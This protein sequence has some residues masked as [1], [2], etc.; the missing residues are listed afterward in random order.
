MSP[1][2][3]ARGWRRLWEGTLRL[4]EEAV[5][6]LA[7]FVMLVVILYQVFMR[8]VLSRPPIWADELARYLYI[9][10]VFLGAALVSRRGTHI[11]MEY[12]P[13]RLRGRSRSLVLLVHEA[14]IVAILLYI[15]KSG[16]EFYRFYARIP[17]PAM[18]LPSAFVVV[19][20][21]LSCVL[22]LLHH[23]ARAATHIQSL[24][25]R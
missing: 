3:A 10:M 23:L 14:A 24:R 16:L 25:A 15:L 17:T 6:S 20:L 8:Y 21:P 18:Q 13:A 2:L 9:W 12:L 7:V 19:V 4:V 5:P 22:M 1:V 11:A